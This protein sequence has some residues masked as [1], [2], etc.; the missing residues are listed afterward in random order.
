MLLGP[1]CWLYI[2]PNLLAVQL[3]SESSTEIQIEKDMP[4]TLDSTDAWKQTGCPAWDIIGELVT[5]CSPKVTNPFEVDFEAILGQMGLSPLEKVLNYGALA[6]LLREIHL[7]NGEHSE[8]GGLRLGILLPCLLLLTCSSFF[9]LL[10][11]CILPGLS[12][13]LPRCAC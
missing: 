7:A 4:M 6:G 12:Q 13:P 1:L 8:L 9:R 10:G 5:K 2:Y 11:R 3:R